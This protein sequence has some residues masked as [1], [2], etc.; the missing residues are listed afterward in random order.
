M[1]QSHKGNVMPEFRLDT[2]DT[3]R[4]AFYDSLTEFGKGYIE[5]AF[6]SGFEYCNESGDVVEVADLGLDQMSMLLLK[7]MAGDAIR[8]EIQNKTE[9]S[10]VC[11]GQYYNKVQAGHDF[12]FT[13]NGCGVGYGDRYIG[14]DIEERSEAMELLTDYAEYMGGFLLYATPR[15]DNADPLDSSQWIIES[16]YWPKEATPEQWAATLQPQ[17]EAET[18]YP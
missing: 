8:F 3:S 11:S 6:F 13:R 14:P 16:E 17:D 12:W 1:N 15:C 5:A 10:L 2:G 18:L 7:G 4:S 9:L